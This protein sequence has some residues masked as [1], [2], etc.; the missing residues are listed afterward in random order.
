MKWVE[1]IFSALGTVN[2][3]SIIF[4]EAEQNKAIRS[5]EAAE[6]YIERAD[7]AF[8]VFK[9]ESEVSAVNRNSGIKFT[10]VGEDTFDLLM[11]A[12]KYGKIT[13][14]AFDVTSKPLNDLWKQAIKNHILPDKKEIAQKR[15]LVNYRDVIFDEN[16][17][18]VK[19]KNVGQEID[20][21][22]IA[23][24]YTLDKVRNILE[25]GVIKSGVINLGGSVCAFGK[26]RKVGLR[27][28]FTPVNAEEKSAIM[29][30][31]ESCNEDIIT[32]G[33]YEQCFKLD[34]KTYHHIIN[35]NSAY[36]ADSGI[37]SA[38]VL[39]NGGAGLDALATACFTL[40][41]EKSIRIIEKMGF[42]A[43]FVFENGQVYVSA[44]LKNRFRMS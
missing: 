33:S 9:R 43:V 15:K 20:L 35:P 13:H 2:N 18:S 6:G 26:S 31:I 44:S 4:P 10:K 28:P 38:T 23:K 24:G 19:L 16:N 7:A 42:S 12:V 8:S 39:G 21:G 37:V 1:K 5:I 11:I 32:S 3:I 17:M 40:G 36:P 22:G 34:G 25:N 30:E 29:A 14:G 41:A 27:N